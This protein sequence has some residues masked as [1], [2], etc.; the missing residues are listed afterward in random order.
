M[1]VSTSNLIIANSG[2]D[3]PVRKLEEIFCYI[4][5]VLVSM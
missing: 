3:L 1:G 2:N 5:K 4:R